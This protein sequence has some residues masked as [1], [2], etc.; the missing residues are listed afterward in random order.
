MPWLYAF[1]PSVRAALGAALKTDTR[2]SYADVQDIIRAACDRG[3]ITVEERLDLKRILAKSITMNDR[4]K[5]ALSQFLK[6][7]DA[8]SKGVDMV[9]AKAGNFKLGVK[10]PKI[11][12]GKFSRKNTDLGKFSHGNFD[13][14]Y[15]PREGR[16]AVGLKVKYQFESGINL[17]ART[18][19][20]NRL[21]QAV[22]AWSNAGAYL[23]SDDFVLNP[24]IQIRFE[25][26][27]VNSGEHFVVDVEK[28]ERREWVGSDLNV[29]QQTT[30]QTFIHE[31][32]HVFGNYDEYR[33]SGFGGWVE[34]RMYWH[35]NDH[36][37][38]TGALMNSGTAFRVRYFDHLERF[39]NE[40]FRDF[41]AKYTA[42]L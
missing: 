21:R 41:G 29:C 32:G 38:D 36:L 13:V 22:R 27:V 19:V 9:A 7:I 34:R 37:A 39:V 16:L 18:G 25:M 17:A 3:V 24:I 5:R 31:L 42:K 8:S 33:G 2:L 30:T 20:M 14:E 15:R 28:G 26:S 4:A 23:E 40:R 1:D 12:P 6:Y 35:D 10:M 11:D